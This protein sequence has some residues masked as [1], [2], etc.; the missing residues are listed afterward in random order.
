[1]T[2]ED[3]AAATGMDTGKGHF[4]DGSSSKPA[5]CSYTVGSSG[6]VELYDVV[7][8]TASQYLTEIANWLLP[9]GANPQ[10]QNAPDLGSSA[11]TACGAFKD[12]FLNSCL[13]VVLQDSRATVVMVSTGPSKKDA[14][15][16]AAA[17]TLA[18]KSIGQ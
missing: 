10:W 5:K 8:M 14:E 9:D 18:K 15:R 1:V 17:I 11:K 3:V 2:R 7:G 6:I 4:T 16:T 13:A 12:P